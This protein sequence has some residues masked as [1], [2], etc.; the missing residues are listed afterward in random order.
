MTYF[1]KQTLISFGA[2]I[3]GALVAW[4]L[5]FGFLEKINIDTLNN[6]QAPGE[7]SGEVV[8]V[9]VDEISFS[10]MEMQWPWPREVH[11]AMVDRLMEE[12]AKQVVFDVVFSEPSNE[13]SD[14]LFAESIAAAKKVVL[15]SDLSERDDGFLAGTV[16][17]RPLELFELNGAKVGLAGVDVDS[18]LV[19]R[20]HPPYPNTLSSVAA[21]RIDSGFQEKSKILR[22]VGPDHS[23]Q[24]VSY[25]QLFIEDG[26]PVDFFKDKTVLIGLDVKAS[27][28]AQA[29]Q[30]DSFP[31][32]F[33]RFNSRLTP[34]V[35]V[36]ANLLENLLFENWVNNAPD[37]HKII[38]LA[39]MTLLSFISCASW[40]PFSSLSLGLGANLITFFVGFYMWSE[41]YFIN[42]LIGL[43]PFIFAY[44]AAGGHAYL[45]E[46]R[47]KRMI[48]G[49]F[50]QYLS[51]AMV[52]SL[53]SD[54]EK[55]QL[56]GERRKMTIMF[57]DVR[58]FTSISEALKDT[59]E[60]LTEIINIL[61]TNLSKDILDC[62]GTIDKYMG[63]CIMAF[64]NA[65]LDDEKHASNSVEAARRMMETITT[66]NESVKSDF[67]LEF[68]LKIGIGIGTGYCVVGNM[69]SD[70]RFDYTVL[71]DIVNLSS[72]LEGQS[73]SYGITTV[74]S[75]YTVEE[76]DDHRDNIIE[77]DMI[78]VKGKVEPEVIYGLSA[79]IIS[80]DER[81]IME[82][83]L[84][85]YREGN[86][87]KAL[88]ILGQLSNYAGSMQQYANLMKERILELQLEGLPDDWDGVY[89]AKSK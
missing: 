83:Y 42:N 29:S 39:L 47:Q 69:G 14:Y 51:P 2:S 45:T 19:V 41:G 57:C 62:N 49:A 18:D 12:G 77:L 74:I 53:I 37:L 88:E 4:F 26:T 72:R 54:P 79:D 75:S 65:P 20:F 38:F 1:G 55:L 11:G 8:I 27:P 35:E 70:Q 50:A 22:Y 64:W 87:G 36:H 24:Y 7:S 85:F 76:V 73:K 21:N 58:G 3:L 86:L 82:K 89:E 15:A 9:G 34:G 78:K 23:F 10:A 25:V 13:E 30:I 60:K 44:L 48:K 71:G 28:D 68:D 80:A 59:P 67:N 6:F 66:V 31:T 81:K 63:D 43:P 5:L 16:E 33:T 17:V 52:D 40:K 84:T 46:G 32:P 56:G 61:L